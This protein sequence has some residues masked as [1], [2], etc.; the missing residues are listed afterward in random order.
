MARTV[1]SSFLF[2][3]PLDTADPSGWRD[4]PANVI[5]HPEHGRV[6]LLDWKQSRGRL[7]WAGEASWR[8]YTAEIE[9]LPVSRGG[10]LGL[11]FHVQDDGVSACNVH[12][13]IAASGRAEAL[14]S[15]GI[16]GPDCAWKLFPEAQAYTIFPAGAWIRL[17]VA[18]TARFA[19]VYVHGSRR[20]V[21][22]LHDLPFAAGGVRLWSFYGS[23]YFRDLKIA[24]LERSERPAFDNPWLQYA[25]DPGLLRRWEVASA[26]R[27]RSRRDELPAGLFSARTRWSSVDADRRGVVNLS[28]AAASLGLKS[29]AFAR[30]LVRAPKAERRVCLFTYTDRLEMWCNREPVFGGPLRGWND[31]GREAHFGGRLIPDEYRVVLPLRAGDN[32]ILVRAER[33]EPWGWGFWMRLA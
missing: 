7:P 14:Q 27:S 4:P 5:G 33:T 22:T 9:I 11:C 10:Y 28:A 24:P 20:P 3:H 8:E 16:W 1:S 12:F 31:P 6:Y 21:L 30:T 2:R 23:G 15:M 13:P 19:N 17:R 32:E 26:G 29:G 18:A 25:G